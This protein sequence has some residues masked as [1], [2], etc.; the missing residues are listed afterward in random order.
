MFPDLLLFRVCA[1]VGFVLG[2]KHGESLRVS[3]PGAWARAN[4]WSI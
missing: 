2:V 1:G 4:P 3:V